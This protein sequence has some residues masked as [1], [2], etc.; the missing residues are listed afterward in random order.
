MIPVIKNFIQF[1]L[2]VKG[3]FDVMAVLSVIAAGL[4]CYVIVRIIKAMTK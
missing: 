1:G 2:T 3:Q 4:V